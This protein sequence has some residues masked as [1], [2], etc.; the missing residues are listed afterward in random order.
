MMTQFKTMT[1][2]KCNPRLKSARMLCLCVYM[3][4]QIISVLYFYFLFWL[5]NDSS[6]LP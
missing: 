1:L 2:T 6:G 5:L 3:C 4:G